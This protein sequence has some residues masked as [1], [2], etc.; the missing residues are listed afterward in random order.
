MELAMQ[1]T[2]RKLLGGI[3]LGAIGVGVGLRGRANPDFTH[4]TYASPGD[5]DD[6][7]LR[8]AWY[9]QYNGRVLKHQGGASNATV[10][11]AL[12]PATEPGYVQ[13]ATFVT[14]G[15]GPVISVGNVLPGDE[16]T[17]VIGLEAVEDG[18]FVPEP[19]DIWLRTAI[20]ADEE[21]GRSGPERAAGDTTDATGE[22][23]DELVVEL[24]RDGS[25]L[26]TCNG[27]KEFDEQ[28]EGPVVAAAPIGEAFGPN[29]AV[30]TATG[31]Q[32]LDGL[33]PGQTRCF[34]LAWSFPNDTLINRAQGDAVRFDLD[35]GGVPVDGASPFDGATT[36]AA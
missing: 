14:D 7:R 32:V 23:D 3:G 8:V 19:M 13:G 17:L 31:I 35:F 36:E 9:E 34:A 24:W 2:R 26:G 22:L 30:A 21:R 5:V 16:G 33:R 28:L 10:D 27:R 11:E 18:E 4:Y 12:D 20:T 6:R 29:S 25:P 1:L 15:T